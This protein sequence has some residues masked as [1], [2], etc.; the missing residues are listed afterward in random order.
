MMDTRTDVNYENQK[1]GVITAGG[2]SPQHPIDDLMTY[3]R[4]Y[5]REQPDTMAC[6][7]F[8]LGFIIGWKL[9]PW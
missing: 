4:R 9:K 7:C 2:T 5:A 3:L 6:I 8:G 1:I